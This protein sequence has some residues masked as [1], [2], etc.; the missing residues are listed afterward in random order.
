MAAC[1]IIQMLSLQTLV[2]L[3][4]K[5]QLLEKLEES[6]RSTSKELYERTPQGHTAL[7]VAALLGRRDMLQLLLEYGAELNGANKS[8]A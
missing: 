3:G 6:K 8:G 4:D 7:D 1:S 5:K 2:E